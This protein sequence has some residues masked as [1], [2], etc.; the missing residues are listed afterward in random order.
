MPSNESADIQEGWLNRTI[1]KH[2][3]M[4]GRIF[5]LL[6][7]LCNA[8]LAIITKFV[9]KGVFFATMASSQA[10]F[11]FLL[12][13]VFFGFKQDAFN[14]DKRVATGLI[15]RGVF[16]S[17]FFIVFNLGLKILPPPKFM[18]INN[19]M[20]VWTV[21]L[22]PFFLNEYPTKL[23]IAMVLLTFFGVALLID[24]S[25]VLPSFLYPSSASSDFP[26]YYYLPPLS[27]GMSAAG[28]GIYLRAFA[29]RIT[30]FQN[31]F[32]FVIFSLMYIGLTLTI[33][34]MDPAT[35]SPLSFIDI[36]ITAF[37]GFF[38]IGFQYCLTKASSLEK[39]A[40]IIAMLLNSQVIFTYI[41]DYFILGH[42]VDLLNL[43]G[44]FIVVIAAV[45][46]AFSREQQARR[47]SLPHGNAG[48]IIETP[49][50]KQADSDSQQKE[51]Y[52]SHKK[53]STPCEY[54]LKR[55]DEDSWH[56]NTPKFHGRV[57]SDL[58]QMD[59]ITF[60]GDLEKKKT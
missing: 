37:Q 18:V 45:I 58:S 39:R 26:I 50:K 28:I 44:G 40:S 12:I 41:L 56:A 6:A 35:D 36:C 33:R 55:I 30:P 43:T 52:G 49:V 22:A 51:M 4:A 19:M 29:G 27:T 7:G 32:H 2:P 25:M 38:L 11:A 3:E 24:P 57:A 10:I 59:N 9:T 5:A 60:G 17:F 1:K 47:A 53:G 20:S 15:L 14:P 13:F 21:I 42:T 48:Q 16:G 54:S 8:C 46:I 34:P 23:I 31:T